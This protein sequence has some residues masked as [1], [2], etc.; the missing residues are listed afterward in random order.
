MIY[1]TVS[2]TD[3]GIIIDSISESFNALKLKFPNTEIYVSKRPITNINV[4][5]LDAYTKVTY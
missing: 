1:F 2:E 4:D 3:C 5:N